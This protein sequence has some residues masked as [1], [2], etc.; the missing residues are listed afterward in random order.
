MLVD[1][2]LRDHSEMLH[3]H[4]LAKTLACRQPQPQPEKKQG[5]RL[6]HNFMEGR[7]LIRS[8]ISA[9]LIYLIYL[10]YLYNSLNH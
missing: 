10:I 3:I 2:N 5:R 9:Y 7:K 8:W 4:M 6:I 1:C